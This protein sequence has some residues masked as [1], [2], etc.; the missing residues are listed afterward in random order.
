MIINNKEEFENFYPYSKDQIGEYPKEYPCI[1]Y[2]QEEGGGLTGYYKQIY[3]IYFPKNLTP[4]EAFIE[5]L[6]AKREPLK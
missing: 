6:S 2:W 3:V 5:G 1:C 4:H